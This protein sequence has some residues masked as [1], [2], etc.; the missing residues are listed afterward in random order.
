MSR[1]RLLYN[2]ELTDSEIQGFENPRIN[3]KKSK[4]YEIH[5]KCLQYWPFQKKSLQYCKVQ[6]FE[7][8][9][10]NGKKRTFVKMLQND[11]KIVH[12]LEHNNLQ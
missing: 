7:H 12:C 11:E 6:G 2:S 5:A 10:K 8:T 1:N 9:R 3:S 4:Y